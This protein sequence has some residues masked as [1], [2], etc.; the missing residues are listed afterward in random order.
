MKLPSAIL[1]LILSVTAP[2]FANPHSHA[3]EVDQIVAAE[4]K[5]LGQ[6]A[7]PQIDDYTFCR[8]LYLDAIGRIPTLDELDQF[9]ADKHADKRARLIDKLLHS[10]GYNSHWYNYWA[11][12]LRV[13]YVGDKLHHP[14][15][16][17]QWVKESVRT[18]KPY[19]KIAHELI[20]AKGKLYEPGNGATGFYAR[21]PM[22]LD[23]LANSVKTFLGM[24]I[25]CAQCHD[26]P[27]DDWTQQDFYKL[28]AF[29]SKTH[30][31]VDP[32]PTEE[33][34]KYAKDREILKNKNFDEWIV[35]R[36]SV[37]VKHASIHGSG[38]GYSRLPHDYEYN[39]GEPHEV[40]AAD[41]LFGSMPEIHYKMA[42]NRVEKLN[43]KQFGPQVNSRKSLADWMTSREN[44][45]FTKAT[46][47]RLWYR[48]M[49][50]ELVGPIGGLDLESTGDHP[51]LTDK[52][53]ELMIAS[54]YDIK[55]FLSVLFNSRTY[56]SKALA[57]QAK[58]PEYVLDGPVVRRLPAEV[59]VDSVLSLRTKDPD[60]SVATE[61]RW[62][63][64]THFYDKSKNMTVKDFVDY[65]V[66]GPGRAKFQKREEKEA[67]KRNRDLGPKS[68]WRV[69][70]YG[71]HDGKYLA[72]ILMGQSTR[73]LIDSANTQPDIPQIL[74][75]I[76]GP[77]EGQVIRNPRG[78]LHQKL[79]NEKDRG[80]RMDMIWKAI[81]GRLPKPSERALFKHDQ[82]DIMWALLNSNEFKFVR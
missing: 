4:L 9:I 8:R 21:E 76:N 82:R 31:R 13:K 27:F 67:Q 29:T 71:H 11:D 3:R 41:V 26:H 50:T 49:G 52:L 60:A 23:H 81:L 7:R 34:E 43:K 63:G 78:Y 73:D 77:L 1:L 58:P 16:Y 51:A 35:F 39:D 2:A 44:P 46:V 59:I 20:N 68:L 62:D 19:D 65:S 5:K 80:K 24:S 42:K 30:L 48:T 70:A 53:V 74:Y 61:F 12:L 10:K 14:G 37:R 54:D 72:S 17:S 55:A 79:R 64:F 36:E 33:K 69:S 15:N 40:M 75:L 22:P 47:N 66:A 18:N 6:K 56:Q 28:A 45:M 32:L 38:T 25:E 57:L